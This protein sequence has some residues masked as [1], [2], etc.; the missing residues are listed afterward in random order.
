MKKY[1]FRLVL[2]GPLQLTEQIAGELFAAGCKDGTPGTCRGVFSIH[3]H[4][5][6]DSLEAAIQSAIQ[7]VKTAGYEVEHAEIEPKSIVE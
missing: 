4:R 7:N 2:K 1:E 3:F 6:A 5:Q